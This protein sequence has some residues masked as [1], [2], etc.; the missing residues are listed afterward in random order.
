VRS[1]ADHQLRGVALDQRE[2]FIG[3]SSAGARTSRTVLNASAT[4]ILDALRI[5]V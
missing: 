1:C 3:R 5:P 4:P 2:G